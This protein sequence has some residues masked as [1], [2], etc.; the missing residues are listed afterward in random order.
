MSFPP[1]SVARDVC[2]DIIPTVP[3]NIDCSLCGLGWPQASGE[4]MFNLFRGNDCAGSAS[5]LLGDYSYWLNGAYLGPSGRLQ[6]LAERG[7]SAGAIPVPVQEPRG[8]RRAQPERV[9]RRW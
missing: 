2:G 6:L 5:G 4:I 9:D 3:V 1:V 7:V 8:G